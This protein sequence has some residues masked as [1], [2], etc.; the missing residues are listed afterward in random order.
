[1][2][3][4]YTSTKAEKHIAVLHYE[5]GDPSATVFAIGATTR[6]YN[7]DGGNGCVC[8]IP[9]TAALAAQIAAGCRLYTRLENGQAYGEDEQTP[10]D[11]LNERQCH[12]L[13]AG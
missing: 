12:S 9:T 1:M 13:A 5:A 4:S 2:H 8:A 6:R 10:N 7:R 11:L 3:L